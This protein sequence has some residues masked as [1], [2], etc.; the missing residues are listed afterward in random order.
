MHDHLAVERCL[1]YIAEIT[2]TLSTSNQAERILHLVVDRLVRMYQCQTGAIITINPRTEYLQITNACGISLTFAKQFHRNISLGAVAD[3]IWTGRSV[4]IHDASSDTERA[5]ELQLEH[6]FVS[7][8]C[9]PL[10]INHRALGYLHLDSVRPYAFNREDLL[11]LTTYAQLA[12]VAID[13]ARLYTEVLHLERIDRESGLEKYSFFTE[14]LQESIERALR[15]NETM[16]IIFFD[17]D[18]YKDIVNTYGYEQSLR[19]IKEFGT[20]VRRAIRP[21]DLAS[22][23]GTDEFIVLNPNTPASV[24]LDQAEELRKMIE[25]SA[26]TDKGI[27]TTVSV[28]VGIFPH[29]GSDIQTLLINAKNAVI[30]AQRAGRNTVHYARRPAFISMR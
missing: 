23:Y 25:E 19:F 16:G 4:M 10:T 30:E 20:H 24:V 12:A 27:R 26:F 18:N 11:I 29:D 15:F 5:E 21:I 7:C 2:T 6:P 17:I 9:I 13:R 28:G 14:R 22:R 1:G 8:I 3:L